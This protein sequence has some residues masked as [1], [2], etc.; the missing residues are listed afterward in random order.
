MDHWIAQGVEQFVVSVGYKKEV[1][2][3]HFGSRY[4]SA[5]LK[6]AVE[7]EPLGTGGGLLLAAQGLS[8]LVLVLNGDTF[9]EVDLSK[10]VKFH[11]AHSADWTFSL[12]RTSEVERYMGIKVTSG[13]EIDS[14][15]SGSE[16]EGRLANG[17]VYLVNPFLFGNKV[18]APN[19]KLSLENDVLPA[20][21]NQGYKLF[22][23]EFSGV[24]I[25]IG[26]PEDYYRAEATLP[27]R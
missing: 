4:R 14:L 12:F 19:S 23:L 10:L 6:Y 20:I 3:D 25:D 13:G 2:M 17:G 21:K 9:F 15:R 11:N 7:Q 5:K 24:F 26:L 22:G 18:F 16:G 27:K 8:D 1:I